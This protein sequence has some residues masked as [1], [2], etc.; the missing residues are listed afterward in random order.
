M[1]HDPRSEDIR[2]PSG[3]KERLVSPSF[4]IVDILPDDPPFVLVE[5]VF[6]KD[7]IGVF[8]TVKNEPAL[9]L[10]SDRLY[11]APFSLLMGCPFGIYI[12]ELRH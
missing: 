7:F 6:T 8:K 10:V 9:P 1:G 12:R 5:D 4:V 2:R 3:R 11:K